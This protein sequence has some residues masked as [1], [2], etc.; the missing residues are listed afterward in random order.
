[1]SCKRDKSSD[2][3]H[4]PEA[5]TKLEELVKDYLTEKYEDPK[6]PDKDVSTTQEWHD[7]YLSSLVNIID[8]I[9]GEI[10]DTKVPRPPYIFNIHQWN[11]RF[12]SRQPIVEKMAKKLEN[13]DSIDFENFEDLI[14]YVEE[15]KEPHFGETAIY[16]FALRYGWNRNPQIK[17]KEYVYIHSKPRRAAQHLVDHGYLKEIEKLERKMKLEK[18]KELLLPGMT[19]HDIEHFLC[20]YHDEI[21]TLK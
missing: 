2:L 1:M 19:A 9:C 21:F 6:Y 5:T 12:P 10:N 7:I 17:P 3:H 20:C 8:F 16:D 18:Y 15:Q 4:N 14:D 11:F 13:I